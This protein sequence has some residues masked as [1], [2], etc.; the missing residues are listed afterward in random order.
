MVGMVAC[1]QHGAGVVRCHN[2]SP[3]Q[4][5]TKPLS[6]TPMVL[7]TNHICRDSF[8]SKSQRFSRLICSGAGA[9]PAGVTVTSVSLDDIK[10]EMPGAGLDQVNMVMKFGGSSV[11]SAERMWEVA[12]IVCAFPEY[13]P[14]VVLSA[15]GPVRACFRQVCSFVK[16]THRC[17]TDILLLFFID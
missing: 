8:I 13:L 4:C 1:S 10:L 6:M 2:Q 11:A 14:C 9:P 3:R 5:S 16:I 17:I 7:P 15:M 12:Q